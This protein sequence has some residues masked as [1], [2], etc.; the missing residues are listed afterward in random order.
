MS[1]MRRFRL[2]R[3]D[4]QLS[5]V[6]FGDPARDYSAVFLHANG[7][8]A[9]T[10]QSILAP[11]GLRARVAGLDL[12]G[13]GTSTLPANPAGLTGWNIIRDDV[14]AF[15]EARAPKGAVLGGH[16]LGATVALMV[17]GKRPDLV[18][19]LLLA[20]P[21]LMPPGRYRNLFLMPG[22]VKLLAATLPI[23]RDARKR[24]SRF[25]DLAEAEAHL[26]DRGAF[27]TWREPF[28]QDFLHD[29]LVP[30]LAQGD[31]P[32]RDRP[33]PLRLACDPAW[34][35]AIY[36]A[37]RH[38]PWQALSRTKCEITL[39]K[40]AAGSTVSDAAMNLFIRKRPHAVV[41]TVRGTTHFLPMETPYAVRDALS[42]YIS[43]HIEGFSPGE[44]GP[45]KRSLNE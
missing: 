40:G 44:E 36:S 39:L 9:M 17:A 41:E 32:T 35:A 24:R 12:R 27:K 22:G 43:R 20:E 16:S 1:Q 34:E 11:L 38:R 19:A 7:F 8:N 5:G 6:E 25:A 18:R 4:G 37:Q 13:H 21:V 30:D 3:P 45:V 42:G 29:G 31:V 10:Y 15:L 14:I 2:E 28:L 26:R 23:A 33:A